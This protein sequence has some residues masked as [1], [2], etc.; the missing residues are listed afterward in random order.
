VRS[1]ESKELS[2]FKI[3]D[4]NCSISVDG[5][6]P[7]FILGPCVI[8]EEDL[9]WKI[10]KKLVEMSR[11][12]KFSLIFKASYDKA[13]RTSIDSFRGPGVKD[14][15]NILRQ[16]GKEFGIPVTTDVHTIEEVEIASEAIDFLQLPAFLCRQTDL[17]TAAGRSGR[18]VNV[19][20]GQFLSPMDIKPIARKLEAVGCEN[21]LFTERGST[22]GYNNLVA[23][24]RSLFWIRE[25]G[26]RVIFDATHSVQRPGGLGDSST[27][28]GYLAPVLA[29]AA[30]ATGCD[31]V[32]IETHPNPIEAKSDGPNQIPLD[33]LRSLIDKLMTIHTISNS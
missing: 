20:K 23:D 29:K 13:N 33:Q 7:V 28:D 8:E 15:C 6:S 21:F 9:V 16:I 5:Q 10:A 4:E 24:M 17:I 19:K 26:Y 2:S 25:Q 31:G 22:F 1:N 30:V 3:G 11:D 32:F 14:G 18:P 12:L 27:G